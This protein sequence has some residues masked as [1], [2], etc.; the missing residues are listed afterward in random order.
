MA[1]R[2]SSPAVEVETA[3]EMRDAVEAALPADAAVMAAAVADWQ[4]VNASDRKMKKDG[5]G[6]PPALEMAENPDI[7][8]WISRSDRRPASAGMPAA[9]AG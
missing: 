3:R 8:A 2:G 9:S 1:G 6:R 7:L 5:S 4:V